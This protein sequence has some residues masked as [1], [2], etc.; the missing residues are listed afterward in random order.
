MII[1]PMVLRNADRA[2]N[3][4]SEDLWGF[5]WV[6]CLLLS[7]TVVCESLLVLSFCELFLRGLG[8]VGGITSGSTCFLLLLFDGN[9]ELDFFFGLLVSPKSSTK[10]TISMS[11]YSTSPLFFC[12]SRLW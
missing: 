6:V 5:F 7:E 11:A 12:F 3:A 4:A 9:F 2:F 8:G 1:E 10:R